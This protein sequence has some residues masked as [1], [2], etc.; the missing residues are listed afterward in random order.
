MGKF[1]STPSPIQRTIA[2]EAVADQV[3]E[4]EQQQEEEKPFYVRW[5]EEAAAFGDKVAD[6]WNGVNLVDLELTIRPSVLQEKLDA[7]NVEYEALAKHRDAIEAKLKA[8]EKKA[9][10]LKSELD[11]TNE[12]TSKMVNGL[13]DQIEADKKVHESEKKLL[14]DKSNKLAKA[15]ELKNEEVGEL[16]MALAQFDNIKKTMDALKAT[17]ASLEKENKDLKDENQR[18]TCLL[19]K[20]N[21]LEEQIKKLTSDKEAILA[22]LEEQ[23]SSEVV[24]DS[25][26][27]DD[28]DDKQE[29]ADSESDS[30]E[31]EKEK[32]QEEEKVAES[33]EKE[34]DKKKDKKEDKDED[35]D[36]VIASSDQ[37]MGIV[38]AFFAYQA[39][40]QQQNDMYRLQMSMA[41]QRDQRALMTDITT[42]DGGSNFLN[43]QLMMMRDIEM[44]RMRSQ[45]MDRYR[46]DSGGFFG[47]ENY[48]GFGSK[49]DSYYGINT[50]R[51]MSFHDRYIK[52][53]PMRYAPQDAL[54]VSSFNPDR[55]YNF[56]LNVSPNFAETSNWQ[57]SSVSFN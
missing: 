2:S 49:R 29:V 56:G 55:A 30:Q 19:E 24:A 44:M 48:D 42:F 45:M 33:N 21:D 37:L 17:I 26:D 27:K 22:K 39:Q 9:Q 35:E 57:P 51:H 52:D 36:E 34:K 11:L 18:L 7:M 32:D 3:Q 25:D 5:R 40:M 15:L 28:S 41:G 12:H 50:G 46:F 13:L 20:Q 1:A 16:K 8:E 14:T 23:N 31:D 6:V 54:P 43:S 4:V 38:N 10:D 47:Q 53:Q